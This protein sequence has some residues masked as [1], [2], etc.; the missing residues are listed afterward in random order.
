MRVGDVLVLAGRTRHGK[1][2]VREQGELWIVRSVR[3]SLPHSAFP[4]GILVADIE[5]L[6]GKHWRSVKVKDDED[7][8]IHPSEL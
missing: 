3:P 1:N 4:A 8:I 5:T 7:F 2:R 6:D